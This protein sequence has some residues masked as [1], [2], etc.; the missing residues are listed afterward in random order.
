MT[1]H[2]TIPPIRS[3]K[4]LGSARGQECAIA[5]PGICNHNPE[6]VVFC[7][8]N[9]AAFGKGMGQKA[10]DIAGF[11]GCSACHLYYDSIHGTTPKLSDADLQ[12]ALL[13]AVVATWVNLITRDIIKVPLDPEPEPMLD[14]PVKPR[15]PVGQRAKV[16]GKSNW[17]APGSTKIESRNNLRKRKP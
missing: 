10:H 3:K 8:L 17:P 16:N 2:F 6:T 9:G 12:R 13:K 4:V 5:L 15:K 11:H 1:A 14:R 7:H